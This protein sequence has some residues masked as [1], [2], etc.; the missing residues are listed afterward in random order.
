MHNTGL[1]SRIMLINDVESLK[2]FITLAATFTVNQLRLDFRQFILRSCRKCINNFDTVE[3]S[4]PSRL[5]S[6]TSNKTA[7]FM[8]TALRTSNITSF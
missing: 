8:V 6:V 5:Q 4:L 2:V 1:Q 7:L 3:H